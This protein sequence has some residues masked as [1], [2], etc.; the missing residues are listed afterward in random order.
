MLTSPGFMREIDEAPFRR[1]RFQPCI[2]IANGSAKLSADT[3]CA[4]KFVQRAIQYL[5]TALQTRVVQHV[6]RGTAERMPYNREIPHRQWKR[7]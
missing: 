2:N 1:S 5:L 3:E 6:L 7:I 4:P